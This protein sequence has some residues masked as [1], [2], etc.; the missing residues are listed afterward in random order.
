MGETVIRI[1]ISDFDLGQICDSGQCF[2]MYRIEQNDIHVTGMEDEYEVVALDKYLRVGQNYLDCKDAN[3]AGDANV[4]EIVFSCDQGEY[5]NFWRDYFD[6]ADTEVAMTNGIT[7]NLDSSHHACNNSSYYSYIK[8]LVRSNPSDV[9]L[10]KAIE[11]GW[12][13]RILNQD[14]WEMIVTFL[15]SQQNNIPR[16]HKCIDNICKKYGQAIGN[17][18]DK[19]SFP[20]PE[21]LA[22]LEEDALM[23]CNLGYRSKYVV[24][25]ARDIVDGKFDLEVIKQMDYL[26]ARA[27]LL[28]MYGVGVKVADCICLF[29]LHHLE[30]FPID[31]HI[32]QVLAREYAEET[33]TGKY[34]KENN[35][36]WAK[37]IEKSMTKG[38]GKSKPKTI[39]ALPQQLQPYT[40]VQG[41]IQQ[42][43]FYA[44]LQQ[45]K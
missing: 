43:I 15:I 39:P 22:Y 35:K 42:Y 33:L 12:G 13:I 17:D 16:I 34:A 37:E 24:R 28:K 40:G 2:R 30:A 32:N 9:F 11:T 6:I 18:K 1:K 21:S 23:E 25:T 20:T 44:E 14:L 45:S 38:S 7:F 8:S 3:Q 27:E 10:N 26:D 41:V 4:R 31:T 5:D 29:A 36:V 19:Y